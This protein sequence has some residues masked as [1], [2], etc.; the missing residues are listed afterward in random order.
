[1]FPT[2]KIRYVSILLAFSLLI[3]Q[4]FNE[5]AVSLSYTQDAFTKIAQMA[6]PAVV[7]IKAG[8]KRSYKNKNDNPSDPYG[9]E[10]WEKFFGLPN[11]PHQQDLSSQPMTFPSRSSR[12][13]PEFPGLIAASVWI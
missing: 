2:L 3:L 6:T 4:P 13:P 7:S 11:N 10:F 9:D 1:M 5:A 8:T 12:G